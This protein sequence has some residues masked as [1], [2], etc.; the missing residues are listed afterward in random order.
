MSCESG[1]ELPAVFKIAGSGNPIY[2]Y[3]T[4]S[5]NREVE[6]TFTGQVVRFVP[7]G[8][9]VITAEVDSLS[10]SPDQINFSMAISEEKTSQDTLTQSKAAILYEARLSGAE[11]EV[12][13]T[14]RSQS[15]YSQPGMVVPGE[16]STVICLGKLMKH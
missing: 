10:V 2:E 15:T 13:M 7:P 16:E 9:G 12:R 6:L 3:Q 1:D 14:V 11:L 5:G 8:G 4:G